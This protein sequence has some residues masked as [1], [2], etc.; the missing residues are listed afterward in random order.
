M[1][2]VIL[3][4]ASGSMEPA[5][6]TAWNVI[7]NTIRKASF[8]LLAF[9][10]RYVD[11]VPTECVHTCDAAVVYDI[12]CVLAKHGM[13]RLKRKPSPSDIGIRFST[14]TPLNDAI[15]FAIYTLE[16][17]GVPYELIVVSDNRDTASIHSM[18]D[19]VDAR[20]K[21]RH[22]RSIILYCVG[23]CLRKYLDP[24]DSVHVVAS[25]STTAPSPFL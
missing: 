17:R 12:G 21:A 9:K 18:K 10:A 23:S 8:I 13:L 5:W 14:R 20:S 7:F 22:L 4:D 19:V 16:K 24:Y 3:L 6:D 15:I 1:L 25:T 2:K 11:S